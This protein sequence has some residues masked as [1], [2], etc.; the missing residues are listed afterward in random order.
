MH[1]NK[2]K[3]FANMTGELYEVKLIALLFL[4]AVN[5]GLDFKMASN[6]QAAGCFDD[7]V[8][9]IGQQTI[10]LQLKHKE[11]SNTV[12]KWS[13]FIRHKDFNLPKYLKSYLVTK[14]QWQHNEDLKLCGKFEEAKFVI[15]TNTKVNDNLVNESASTELLNVVSTGGKLVCFTELFKNLQ[16]Y[17]Q[18]LNDAVNSNNFT[19]SS[20]LIQIIQHLSN[21]D[22][23][24][25]PS[26][27]KL[28]K[29]LNDLEYLG[30]LSSYDE[31]VKQLFFY[32]EQVPEKDLDNLIRHEIEL[33]CGTDK[34]YNTFMTGI[35]DWWRNSDVYLSNDHQF[36]QDILQSCVVN[37]TKT[38]PDFGI[39]VFRV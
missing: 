23:K 37:V 9:N 17:K 27:K 30:D 26:S 22:I 20:D 19:V 16:N 12:I 34:M 15:F 28:S 4:R 6:M 14:Q 3:G 39:K 35:Q 11:K 33:V 31:F 29:L 18:T 5:N 32:T 25:Q 10:F 38:L 13:Q 36:W 2:M 1:F 8:F 7:I 24:C 21:K